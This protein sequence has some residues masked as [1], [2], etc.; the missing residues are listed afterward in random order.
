MEIITN[1]CDMQAWSRR[2]LA[3]GQRIACVPT[4]GYLHEGHL[5]LIRLARKAADQVVVTLFVNPTQFGPNEDFALYPRDPERDAALCRTEGVAALFMPVAEQF[6]AAD[7]SVVVTEESLSRGLCGVS[8]PGHFQ[9][10]CTVVAKLFNTVSPQVAVFGRKDAQQAAIIKRMV[11]DLNF[12]IEIILGPIVR[13]PD[14][15]AI[16]SRNTRLSPAE[17]HAALALSRLL[18]SVTQAYAAGLRSSATVHEMAREDLTAS[19]LR[20]DYIATVDGETLQ[21]VAQLAPGVLVALAAFAG[22]VRLIDNTTL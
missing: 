18:K 16:S 20:I 19:G 1:A 13:E 9:G 3:A 12:P 4:M 21:P 14:G 11:R 17:R 7:A 10:V 2:Q 8:R 5:S 6:Y 22:A 15:L